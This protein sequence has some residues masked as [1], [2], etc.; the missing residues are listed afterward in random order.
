MYDMT[1]RHG[2]KPEHL[3]QDGPHVDAEYYKNSNVTIIEET[4]YTKGVGPGLFG[5][6]WPSKSLEY[7][8]PMAM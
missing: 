3:H 6:A 1:T 8:D 2:M 7:E 5:G 4:N